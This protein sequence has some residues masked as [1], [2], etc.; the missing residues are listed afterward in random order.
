M[1]LKIIILLLI[2]AFC[3][4]QLSA[5][6]DSLFTVINATD[7]VK[8]GKIGI[9][10]DAI[11]YLDYENLYTKLDSIATD[12]EIIYIA[13]KGNEVIKSYMSRILTNRKSEYISSL[14][15]QYIFNN[16]EIYIQAG[17]TGY[18]TSFAGE[19]YENVFYQKNKIDEIEIYKKE[20]SI[21]EIKKSNLP[22][23]TNWTKPEVDS[24]LVILN[25]T[26]LSNDNVLPI[27][28]KHIFTLNKFKFDNYE[29]VKYFA[30]K[31]PEIEILATLAS[32][33]NKRDLPLF[34]K[35][36]D[37]S[38]LAIS[39][40][41]DKSFIP[42]LKTKIDKG[43]Y[44]YQYLEA[45]ASFSDKDSEELLSM[46]VAKFETIRDKK[47]EFWISDSELF[48]HFYNC[49]EKKSSHFNDGFLLKLWTNNKI[50][51]FTFFQKIKD[52]YYNELVKGFINEL[53]FTTAPINQN[54][55]WQKYSEE[56]IN[57]YLCPQILAYLK[58]NSIL[59]QDKS[60]NLDT[61]KCEVN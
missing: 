46:I 55:D 52:K 51:S 6:V 7:Q 61:L 17:C 36:I 33:Q 40:F 18:Q 56:E 30:N 34:H 39:K 49:L 35:N 60:I 54:S 10:S 23:E 15:S 14:F 22:F 4:S 29:R 45:A 9:G 2:P 37:N 57:G 43:F 1:K 53:P 48:G 13:E 58:S 42:E 5:K 31:H 24:L 38:F 28:L 21:E 3:F 25:K 11:I 47:R 27:T 41:P 32:F 20:F 19:L 16:E 8:N 50:I 44:D 26:V 12:E 59:N